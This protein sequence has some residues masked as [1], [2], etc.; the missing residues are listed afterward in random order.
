MI[1][2]CLDK[3]KLAISENDRYAYEIFRVLELKQVFDICNRPAHAIAERIAAM[4]SQ[5]NIQ[6]KDG[7]ST[8]AAMV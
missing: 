6:T 3:S 8:Q 7:S 5:G 4:T 2:S 1:L